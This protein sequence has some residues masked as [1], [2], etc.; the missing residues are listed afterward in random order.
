VAAYEAWTRHLYGAG[1]FHTAT[2]YANWARSNSHNPLAQNLLEGLAYDG[3]CVLPIVLLAP[4]LW[5][6]RLPYFILGLVPVLIALWY[7]GG[8]G[9]DTKYSAFNSLDDW[10]H[11]WTAA[12]GAVLLLGGFG[13]PALL[14]WAAGKTFRKNPDGPRPE[15]SAASTNDIWFLLG[16]V[17]VT[18]VF[19]TEL[20]WT[21]SAR[22]S[23]PMIPPL[24]TLIGMRL[25]ARSLSS[26]ALWTP[27]A[28]C[29]ALT[30]AITQG[31]WVQANSER[32]EAK[33]AVRAVAPKAHAIWCMGAWGFAYYLNQLGA[34]TFDSET[35]RVNVRDYFLTAT[36]VAN[37][38]VP[39]DG[40]A[41][42][43]FPTKLNAFASTM[44]YRND[45]GFYST[46]WGQLPFSFFP[47]PG[48]ETCTVYGLDLAKIRAE[49]RAPANHR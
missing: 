41:E 21:L 16:W 1:L 4:A 40:I 15:G 12:Q 14:V 7:F 29:A 39:A 37:T 36:N 11:G 6:K 23:L 17:A 44:N 27:I 19:G 47:E 8:P 49:L 33:I 30:L 45:A 32:T 2:A 26:R 31:D 38:Q 5:G 10:T 3:G 28:L 48:S 20:N 46:E 42:G 43:S 24:A 9:K 18:F 13:L 34:R 25:E 22:S 35:S